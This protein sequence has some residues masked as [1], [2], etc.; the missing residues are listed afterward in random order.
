MVGVGAAIWTLLFGEAL[1]AEEALLGL[2][3]LNLL[4]RA[5]SDEVGAPAS[6][7]LIGEDKPGRRVAVT[8]SRGNWGVPLRV[9]V[10]VGK[11]DSGTPVVVPVREPPEPVQ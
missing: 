1:V 11:A 4:L 5:D 2:V 8:P 3:R 10:V 6:V 9:A 7:P